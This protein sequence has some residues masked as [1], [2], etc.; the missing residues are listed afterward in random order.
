MLSL[1]DPKWNE[2]QGP[3]YTVPCGTSVALGGRSAAKICGRSFGMSSITKVMLGCKP[4]PCCHGVTLH[5]KSHALTDPE[6]SEHMAQVRTV[7]GVG[8]DRALE[9]GCGKACPDGEREDIDQLL[10][11]RAEQ[12]RT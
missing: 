5:P 3:A 9:I 11:L 2:F 4:K 8:E 6:G 7:R 10:R 12:M 1:S